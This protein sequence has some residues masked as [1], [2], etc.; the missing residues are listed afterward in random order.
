M[1]VRARAFSAIVVALIAAAGPAS[2]ADDRYVAWLADGT[3]LT[4]TSLA[5]WPIPGVEF[6]FENQDLLVSTNPVR[7]VRDRRAHVALKVPFVVLANGDVLG[8]TPVQLEPDLGRVGQVPR[9]KVQLE[10]PL[11]PVSGTGISV[12]IDR[13]QRIVMAADAART[14][15]PPGTVVLADGRRLAARSIRWREYGLAILTA[16]GVVEAAFGDL[17]DAVFPNVD[18]AAG[19]LDDNLWAGGAAGNS[20]VRMQMTG[21]SIVTGARISREQEQSRRRGRLTSAAYYYIQP[22]WA[23]QPLAL[24]EQEL[25]WCGYRSSSEAPLSL[26]P[27]RTLANR[28]L[29]SHP[30]PWLANHAVDGGPLSGGGREADTGVAAHAYSAIA[31]DLPAA[32]RTLELAVG[33]D[34]A[35]GSG[36]CVRCKVVAESEQGTVLWDSGV[37]QGRDGLRATGPI[38]VAAL[39]RVVLVTEFAD[40]DRPAGADPLD[41]RDQVVWLAPLVKLD[42]E[43]SGPHGRVVTVLPGV[44]D[45]QLAGDGWR[46]AQIA[47]RWNIINSG[48]DSVLT[49]P[50]GAELRLSRNLPVTSGRDIVELLT[51]SPADL[52]EHDFTLTVNGTPVPWANNTDRNQLRQWVQ[53]YGRQ[54]A[55]DDDDEARLTDRLA[56]WWDLQPWRGQEVAL[57]LT[58]RGKQDRSDLVWRGIAVRSAIGNLAAGS[59]SLKPDVL[60]TSLAPLDGTPATGRS[61]P[62][63]DSVGQPRDGEPIRFLGQK[64][65]GGYGL[66]RNSSISFPID[67]SYQRFTAVAGCCSQVA[68][69]LQILVDGRIVW[70]RPFVSSLDPAEQIDLPI[71]QGSKTLTLRSADSSNYGTAA[72]ANAGFMK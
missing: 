57:E 59:E 28:R 16:E 58:L 69:P 50:R 42:L 10:P 7:L 27:A 6:R 44:G 5:K 35:V 31:F 30:E 26:L 9:V 66:P 14:Q 29:L 24:P 65:S 12:R 20:I 1:R 11:L 19:V 45:W 39:P 3:K 62:V 15:P 55:R 56:Y 22:S 2:A 41:I 70:E 23:D 40:Q 63:K 37:I 36:G 68:G 49:L 4:A 52:A 46:S 18:V 54:R 8:G 38:D 67:S 13:I 43:K 60:I 21:G 61:R 72:F 64:F 47:N 33:L 71:P 32:A 53:R 17:V 34:R 48:W 25:A 51:T